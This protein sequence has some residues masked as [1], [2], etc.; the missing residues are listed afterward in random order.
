[1]GIL[2]LKLGISPMA[3]ESLPSGEN[4]NRCKA[5]TWLLLV[6]KMNE[7]DLKT[8]L[9]L[10]NIPSFG[11]NVVP[12]LDSLGAENNPKGPLISLKILRLTD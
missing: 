6:I 2:P 10:I 9:K 8:L 3:R 7:T 1:V 11:P 4:E 12:T 5:L